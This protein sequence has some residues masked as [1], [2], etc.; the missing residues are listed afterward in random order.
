MYYKYLG[1]VKGLDIN[2]FSDGINIWLHPD[3][4]HRQFFDWCTNRMVYMGI[5][6]VGG[7]YSD[8]FYICFKCKGCGDTWCR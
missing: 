7:R 1:L 4:D 2:V 6:E 3:Y 8:C 5:D